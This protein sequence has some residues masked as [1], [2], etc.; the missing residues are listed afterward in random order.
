VHEDTI[1]RCVNPACARPMPR[2]VRFCPWCGT[3]QATGQA[4]ARDAGPASASVAA[5]ASAAASTAAAA[6]AVPVAAAV[7][8]VADPANARVAAGRAGWSGTPASQSASLGSDAGGGA[9]A[10]ADTRAGAGT[11]AP[12]G[13]SA[14]AQAGA[15]TRGAGLGTLFGHSGRAPATPPG[16]SVPRPPIPTRPA[17]PQRAPVRLRWWVLFLL[18][19]GGVWLVARPNS[20]RKI[21]QRIDHAIALAEACKARDAQSELIALR[22]TR[23]SD[24]QLERL[25]TAL[26][27]GAA[28]CTRKRQRDRA[29]QETSSSAETAL[30]E[31]NPERARARLQAFTRRWGD[32]ERTRALRTRI[33]DASHPLA[34]PPSS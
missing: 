12:A 30:A 28:A 32:D 22:S 5:S 21:E 4:P 29:W 2:P 20:S 16:E 9:G 13:A 6:T 3:A 15:R 14:G 8:P 7:P 27:E 1:Y 11:A 10:G 18:V 24:A 23:A 34:V 31:Q 17:T 33:E 26:N 19:L 25:Q